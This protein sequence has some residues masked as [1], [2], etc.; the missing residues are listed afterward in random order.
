MNV[1]VLDAI[2]K[3]GEAPKAIGLHCIQ[4]RFW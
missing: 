4:D 2:K 3:L 1:V